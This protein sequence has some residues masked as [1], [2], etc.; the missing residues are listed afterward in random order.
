MNDAVCLECGYRSDINDFSLSIAD[1]NDPNPA[2]TCPKCGG[3]GEC[4]D[5]D[6]T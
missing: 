6:I 4:C 2:I 5:S 1:E 3:C